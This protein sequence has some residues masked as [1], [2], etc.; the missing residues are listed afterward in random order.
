MGVLTIGGKGRKGFNFQYLYSTDLRH[1]LYFR[2]RSV[3]TRRSLLGSNVFVVRS[4]WPQD[5]VDGTASAPSQRRLDEM[6]G[7]NC[8]ATFL[9]LNSSRLPRPYD[10]AVGNAGL[11]PICLLPLTEVKESD[12]ERMQMG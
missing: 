10:S 4:E 7:C 3:E 1:S 11:D 5:R 9:Q 6:R 2:D 12:R 8:A